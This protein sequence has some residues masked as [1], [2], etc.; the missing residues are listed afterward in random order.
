MTKHTIIV[1]TYVII[2]IIAFI[3]PRFL[4]FIPNALTVFVHTGYTIQSCLIFLMFQFGNNIYKH[5]CQNTLR[6]HN[7]CIKC[8]N[9]LDS[10]NDQFSEFEFESSEKKN[11]I[12][13][14]VIESET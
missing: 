13:N 1:I 2:Q 14:I 5:F 10:N 8:L 12:A 3:L 9:Q 6:I 7:S 11:S 4:T